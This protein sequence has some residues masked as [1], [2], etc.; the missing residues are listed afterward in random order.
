MIAH[1]RFLI[2]LVY[3]NY[4]LIL[5]RLCADLV[6]MLLVREVML[7]SDLA[8]W[9]TVWCALWPAALVVMIALTVA[10]WWAGRKH[11]LWALLGLLL[12]ITVEVVGTLLGLPVIVILEL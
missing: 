2:W 11:F 4:A 6:L 8:V 3:A 7:T 12:V 9:D 5:L 10:S 1:G